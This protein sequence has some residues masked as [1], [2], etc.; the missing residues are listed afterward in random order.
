MEKPGSERGGDLVG[1]THQWQVG[2]DFLLSLCDLSWASPLPIQPQMCAPC[3]PGAPCLEEE[4]PGG[5]GHCLVSRLLRGCRKAQGNRLHG[6]K[7]IP[8]VRAVPHGQ[9]LPQM[10]GRTPLGVFSQGLQ[11]LG[12][13]WVGSAT[14]KSPS[15]Q[16]ISLF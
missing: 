7:D 1:A 14:P 3:L 9:R 6:R 12:V 2:L 5:F 15:R 16:G 11:A 4:D 8:P 13:W 10:E